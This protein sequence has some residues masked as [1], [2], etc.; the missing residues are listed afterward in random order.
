VWVNLPPSRELA[1]KLALHESGSAVEAVTELADA[2]YILAGTLGGEGLA[3]AWYDK[4]EFDAGPRAKLTTDHSPGCSTTSEYPVRSE[5]VPAGDAKAV[6][7]GAAAL[8]KYASLLAKV[9]GWLQLADNPTGA[10]MARYYKL[11]M[12]HASDQTQLPMDQAAP[13][14]ER[15]QLALATGAQVTE[16]RWVYVLDID[17]HGK[18]SLLYPRNYSEN[19]FPNDADTGR[20][21]VLRGAPTLH[22]GP[23]YG[24]D[25]L[26]MLSTA[27]PLPDPYALE[28]EG[29][30]T[31]GGGD[32]SP[33]GR[34]LN[35]ASRGTRGAPGEVPT[36]WGLD[37]L[38]LHSVPKDAAK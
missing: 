12:I 4:Q 14:D 22:I 1:A 36:N 15:L 13:E 27:Q 25:T 29:V 28:F 3:Y 37:L 2:N 31:R 24:V 34:L 5:W 6:E 10:S 8:N 26:V 18:G 20:E 21:F 9:H 16:R 23:P 17:C 7:E 30:A 32:D 33:L 35:D 11:E 38:T 19:Q